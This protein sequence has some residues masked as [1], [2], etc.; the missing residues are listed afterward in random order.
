MDINYHISFNVN[1]EQEFVEF[2]K[3][4]KLFEPDSGY[5]G[6]FDILQSDPRWETVKRFVDSHSLLCHADSVFSQEELLQAQWLRIRSCWHVG[7]PQPEGNFKYETITYSC[8]NH[9]KECGIGLEQIAPFRIKNAPRWTS[10]HFMMLNWVSDE[11]FLDDTAKAIL[12]DASLTGIS[13]GEVQN[14]NGSAIVP[15]VYQLKVQPLPNEG[16]IPERSPIRST[17]VCEKCGATRYHPHG[18]GKYTFRKEIF[19]DAPDIVKT[20]ELFGWGHSSARLILIR[21][22]V[23]RLLVEK[24]LIRDLEFSPID[25]L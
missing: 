24:K 2:L 11:L 23:Y 7:Y 1:N 3:T 20:A 6:A 15:G 14:K 5:I 18:V 8:E 9:C 16:L 17:I 19:D 22:C 4:E 12:E 13:F 25:L 10:R 21:Q